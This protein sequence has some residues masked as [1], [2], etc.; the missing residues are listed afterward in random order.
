MDAL[1]ALRIC[2]CKWHSRLTPFE[3]V[4]AIITNAPTRLRLSFLLRFAGGFAGRIIA[5]TGPTGTFIL[6][7]TVVIILAHATSS[8]QSG[9]ACYSPIVF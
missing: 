7:S 6:P 1:P 4:D 3:P 9:Y 8:L 5:D 2:W